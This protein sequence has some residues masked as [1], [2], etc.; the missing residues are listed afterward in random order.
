MVPWV[1]Q[2]FNVVAT[3]PSSPYQTRSHSLRA[4]PASLMQSDILAAVG[5]A[6]STRSDTFVIRCYGD[7][8]DPLNPARTLAG[9]WIEAIVQRIPEFCDP[10][11]PP[12]TEVCSP[13][14]GRLHN[15]L[16]SIINRALGRRFVIL[17]ARI[18]TQ[19]DL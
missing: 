18:L 4:A 10:S 9:C 11:Q 7:A 12:E 15:P 5:S 3:N 14:D 8:T 13:T 17:S 2:R 1:A 19:E 6:L 16:L